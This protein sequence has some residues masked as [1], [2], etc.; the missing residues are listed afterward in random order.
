MCVCPETKDLE[1]RYHSYYTEKTSDK[2]G[3]QILTYMSFP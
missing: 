3:T 1:I 2:T